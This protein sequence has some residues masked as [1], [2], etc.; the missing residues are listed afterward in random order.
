MRQS[1]RTTEIDQLFEEQAD[2]RARLLRYKDIERKT[3]LS[4]NYIANVIG[5]MVRAKCELNIIPCEAS[6]DDNRES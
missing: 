4:H 5:R 1:K 2:L 6:D 3:G